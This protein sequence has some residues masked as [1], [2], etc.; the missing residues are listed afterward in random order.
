MTPPIPIGTAGWTIPKPVSD[1][2]PG[3]GSQLERYA[4]VMT[5]AEINSSFYKPHRRTT[6]ERWA[7][8][9]P[10]GFRF[11]VKTP[12]QLTQH[13][14]LADPEPGLDQFA[15]EVAGL[16]EKLAVVLVQ[17]PPSLAFEEAVADTFFKALHDR[18]DA[19]VA[20]EPR[21]ASWA[22]DAVDAWLAERRVARVA[23]DPPRGVVS[24]SNADDPQPAVPTPGGWRGLS[25]YRLHGS[26][27]IY[28]SA[29]ETEFLDRLAQ[30][31]A[32]DAAAG[33]SWCI[34]DNTTSGAALENALSLHAQL[35]D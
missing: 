24:P 31:L 30:A 3:E 35:A 15:A 6:Y 32:N 11:S 26:P 7:A 5:A 23:A 4:R 12:R 9:T 20:C 29:Y 18:V 16:G 2:F 22:S 13:Q 19:A 21:H 8:S 25:Y 33:H 34:F 14:K 17:L 28:Y 27:R 1:Q 10:P